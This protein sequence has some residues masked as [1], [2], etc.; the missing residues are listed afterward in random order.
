MILLIDNYDSFTYNLA[1]AIGALGYGDR[2][3]VVLNDQTT[4]ND[5]ELLSPTH[6]VISPGP[7]TP[8]ESG[9]SCEVIRRFAGRAAILG[10]CLG[11]QCIAQVFG[12]R[13]VRAGRIMHGKTSP[14]HHIDSGIHK[15]LANP[16]TAARYHSLSVEMKG[17][18]SEFETT[19][20][21][22]QNELMGIRHPRLRLEGVQYH[23]ESYLTIEGSRLV[24]NFLSM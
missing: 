3:R 15:G 19:A 2:L 7:C 5:I 22:E 20:W 16:F 9:I 21:T 17:M 24:E 6:I 11:H 23:P 4:L 18:P 1:Q 10:V 13:V 14:I 8:K 12:G